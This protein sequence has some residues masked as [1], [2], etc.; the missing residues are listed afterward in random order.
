MKIKKT[1]LGEKDDEIEELRD[2]LMQIGGKV[3][4]H[5]ESHSKLAKQHDEW[6]RVA[7]NM[8]DDMD[9]AKDLVQEMYLEVIEG[10]RNIK[11]IKFL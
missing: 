7:Y 5:K 3:N 11:D 10:T 9:E 4:E 8:T 1:Q 6:I 2:Q